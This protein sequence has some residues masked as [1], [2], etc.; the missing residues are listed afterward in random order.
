MFTLTYE[1]HEVKRLSADEMKVLLENASE[2]NIKKEI[3]GCLIYYKGRFIQILEG[4]KEAVLEI[5]EKIKIDSRHKKVHLFSQDDITNRTFPNW[6]MAY[7]PVD[8]NDFNENELEQFKRNLLLLADLT[9]SK[10]V[11]A[12]LFWKRIKFYLAHPD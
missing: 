5:Y 12:S 2:H 9:T 7:Y 6:G 3:T 1:S 8:E 11:T 4:E 10:S